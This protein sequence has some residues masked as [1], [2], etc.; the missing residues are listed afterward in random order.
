MVKLQG[1]PD[2]QDHKVVQTFI[3]VILTDES[4][5]SS[6]YAKTRLPVI[7]MKIIVM[8]MFSIH[9]PKQSHQIVKVTSL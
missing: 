3:S 5:I 9:M 4:N 8:M 2:N 7:S 1:Y 6:D